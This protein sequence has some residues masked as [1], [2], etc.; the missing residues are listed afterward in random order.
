ML[1]NVRSVV[2]MVE[3]IAMANA[4]ATETVP[5]AEVAT[6]VVIHQEAEADLVNVR[7]TVLVQDLVNVKHTAIVPK[8]EVML[9]E[10]AIAEILP[11]S[12]KAIATVL[13]KEVLLEKHPVNQEKE[14]AIF[15]VKN[16]REKLFNTLLL[17]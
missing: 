6:E 2:V 17:P 11:V 1:K 16:V 7:A 12:A 13:I 8:E 4:K 10:L 15:H 14:K 5:T 9:K 3:A